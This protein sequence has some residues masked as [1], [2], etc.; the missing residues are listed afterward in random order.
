MPTHS[1]AEQ[2]EH[3]SCTYRPRRCCQ[4]CCLTSPGPCKCLGVCSQAAQHRPSACPQATAGAVCPAMCTDLCAA[5]CLSPSHSRTVSPAVCSELCAAWLQ[6]VCPWLHGAV[7]HHAV[8]VQH[9]LL[10]PARVQWCQV[11]SL[12][13]SCLNEPQRCCLSYR[14][15][16]WSGCMQP[17]V[18]CGAGSRCLRHVAHFARSQAV[19]RTLLGLLLAPAA[20]PG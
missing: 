5:K 10:A 2:P 12:C 18:C 14:L 4:Q 6:R 3:S 13:C 15:G 19:A 11:S 17:N 7:P 16:C 8:E 1:S 9:C 20:F